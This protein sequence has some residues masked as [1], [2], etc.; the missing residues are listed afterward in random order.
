MKAFIWTAALAIDHRARLFGHLCK[1][2]TRAESQSP[3]ENVAASSVRSRHRAAA[4][5][6]MSF[7][8]FA[9]IVLPIIEH[10]D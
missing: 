6:A 10:L 9:S 7:F 8:D 3:L 2:W 4:L 5:P 1:I